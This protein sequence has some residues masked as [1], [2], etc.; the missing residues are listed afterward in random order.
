MGATKTLDG[1]VSDG[2]NRTDRMWN[3][4]PAKTLERNIHNT[5]TINRKIFDGIQVK[6]R[7]HLKCKSGRPQ[8]NATRKVCQGRLTSVQSSVKKVEVNKPV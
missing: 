2:F 5:F 4:Q 8:Q 7:M 3:K 1:Y 6:K